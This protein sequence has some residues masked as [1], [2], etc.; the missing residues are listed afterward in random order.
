MVMQ[1]ITRVDY[2]CSDKVLDKAWSVVR[3]VGD[4]VLYKGLTLVIVM[5]NIF[6]FLNQ[7]LIGLFLY[8]M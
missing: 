3:V 4:K 8:K 2:I 6:F 5:M 7:G 1:F